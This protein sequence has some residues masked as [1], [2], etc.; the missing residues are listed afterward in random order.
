[1]ID[2]MFTVSRVSHSLPVYLYPPL[3]KSVSL[4]VNYGW[5]GFFSNQCF[6]TQSDF[7]M[8]RTKKIIEYSSDP[9]VV[10]GLK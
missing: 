2:N 3:N 7:I 10:E 5:F 9:R 6:F 8:T 4:H 1:M